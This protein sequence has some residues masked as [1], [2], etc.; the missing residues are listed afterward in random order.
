[1]SWKLI[2]QHLVLKINYR[3]CGVELLI[4]E[5]TGSVVVY[6]VSH[7]CAHVRK[8]THA[9]S[10]SYF[11]H[12]LLVFHV[13]STQTLAK[14]KFLEF[15]GHI[16]QHFMKTSRLTYFTNDIQKKLKC[17]IKGSLHLDLRPDN[18]LLGKLQPQISVFKRFSVLLIVIILVVTQ[19]L[20]YI[21]RYA[22]LYKRNY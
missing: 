1:M 15:I 5:K 18:L 11:Y 7:A 6:P 22:F 20:F 2:L 21:C 17:F 13:S 14:E 4:S 12:F 3:H 10:H 16:K 9:Y 19:T 8:H